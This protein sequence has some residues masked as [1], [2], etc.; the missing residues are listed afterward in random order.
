MGSLQRL[1]KEGRRLLRR[2]PWQPVADSPTTRF[3]TPW[4]LFER[5]SSEPGAGRALLKPLE[6]SN[7]SL[8][9]PGGAP[10][11]PSGA[12]G[13]LLGPGSSRLAA[14]HYAS[15]REAAV[16]VI[17][18]GGYARFAA[19]LGPGG[20]WASAHLAV[21]VKGSGARLLIEEAVRGPGSLGLEL[22]LEPGTSLE[23]LQVVRVE[24]GA[25]AAH[26]SRALLSRGSELRSGSLAVSLSGVLRFEEGAVVEEG[27]SSL[28]SGGFA[29]LGSSVLDYVGN[30]VHTGPV[31][32]SRVDVVGV[33]RDRARVVVRG[34]IKAGRSARGSRTRLVTS[35]LM[36]GDGAWG[37]TAP[38]LE[39]DTGA[40]EEASHS[41]H[42]ARLSTEQL[43]Y[44]ASR[45]LEPG[46]IEALV[47]GGALENALKVLRGLRGA[48]EGYIRTALGFI[49]R[50]RG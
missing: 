18:S 11:E 44:L 28:H 15:L 31:S 30:L 6:L 16:L 32:T 39:V 47:T 27:S 12:V 29:A 36:L 48:G 9:R 49:G 3:Y 20:S 46:E 50:S 33:A 2:I 40:V 26:I 35:V 10:E 37:Y 42:H 8:L 1:V 43:A 5:Y 17:N 7:A 21:V 24:S 38:F 14:L 13:R 45:G 23:I 4:S 22:L 41:A 34:C 19:E 25:P